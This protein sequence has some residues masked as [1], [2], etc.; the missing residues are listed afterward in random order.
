LLGESE[1]GGEGVGGGRG[2]VRVGWCCVCEIG[3]EGVGGNVCVRLQVVAVL[4]RP[5]QWVGGGPRGGGGGGA[6]ARHCW[7]VFGR[8]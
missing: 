3:S 2:G 4:W 6:L 7:V 1:G 5:P 8:C